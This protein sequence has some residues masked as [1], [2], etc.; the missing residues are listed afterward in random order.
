MGTREVGNPA[1]DEKIVA[2][3]RELENILRSA[4]LGKGRLRVHIE[5][6]A[7]HH[8]AAWA[9]RFPEALEF[10]YGAQVTS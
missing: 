4:G 1:K 9:A 10:L 6:G 5:E 8:E 3:V 2:D 7:T